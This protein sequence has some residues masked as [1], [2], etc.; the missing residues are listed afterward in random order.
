MTYS[1]EH[2]MSI[3]RIERGK[4]A[5]GEARITWEEQIRMLENAGCEINRIIE[6][7]LG[8]GEIERAGYSEALSQGAGNIEVGDLIFYYE[9]QGEEQKIF[10]VVMVTEVDQQTGEIR[11][12][13][14]TTDRRN[15]LL[16]EA[17]G[18]AEDNEAINE[19]TVELDGVT[20][21]EIVR[22]NTVLARRKMTERGRIAEDYRETAFQQAINILI[23]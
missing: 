16:R 18:S 17:L 21:I 5:A 20:A 22:P 2:A 15:E 6:E 1:T 14:N 8:S 11:I 23:Q 9:G 12:S 13:G 3:A 7:G 10:H 19:E 4:G